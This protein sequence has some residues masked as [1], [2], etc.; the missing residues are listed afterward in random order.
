M[1]PHRARSSDEHRDKVDDALTQGQVSQASTHR[2]PLLAQLAHNIEN[3]EQVLSSTR[4]HQHSTPPPP[5]APDGALA[6]AASQRVFCRTARGDSSHSFLFACQQTPGGVT[7]TLNI[8]SR[9]C[10]P[11]HSSRAQPPTHAAR[12]P[13]MRPP[14]VWGGQRPCVPC[15]A[16]CFV[17][18][19]ISPHRPWGTAP[20]TAAA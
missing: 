19:P 16:I 5:T 1:V 18:R 7:A 6:Q 8:T 17:F 20:G 4:C 10:A 13:T 2:G 11:R 3:T 15:S 14:R 12:S 9:T